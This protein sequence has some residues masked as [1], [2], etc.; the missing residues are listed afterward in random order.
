MGVTEEAMGTTSRDSRM[1]RTAGMLFALL[2]PS[3]KSLAVVLPKCLTALAIVL[4]LP[5]MLQSQALLDEAETKLRAGYVAEA[6]A[7]YRQVVERSPRSIRGHLGLAKAAA[8]PEG[9]TP[10]VSARRIAREAL[11]LA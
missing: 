2:L 10:R 5:S 9:R 1:L 8:A 6:E 3:E 11:A 7:L 4:A